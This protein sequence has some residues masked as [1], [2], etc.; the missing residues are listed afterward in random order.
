M[1]LWILEPWFSSQGIEG[2]EGDYWNRLWDR[3]L[4]GRILIT[5]I[6]QGNDF[7][8]KAFI[9]LGVALFVL[10]TPLFKLNVPLL[11]MAL[12]SVFLAYVLEQ[13]NSV[14]AYFENAKEK[15]NSEESKSADPSGLA[16]ANYAIPLR[17]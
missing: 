13:S 3:S 15:Y 4:V 11:A 7:A 17:N 1:Y 8:K 12:Y 10:L 16:L 5:L 14:L 9:L 2:T 6:F